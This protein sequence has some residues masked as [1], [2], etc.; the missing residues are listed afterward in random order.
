MFLFDT[1]YVPAIFCDDRNTCA[2]KIRLYGRYFYWHIVCNSDRPVS[3]SIDTKPKYKFGFSDESETN[4]NT[5]L[6]L[7]G[8]E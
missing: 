4:R 2:G 5:T 7:K 8:K 6:S 3:V 1:F